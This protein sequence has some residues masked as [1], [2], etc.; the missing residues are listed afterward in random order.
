[1]AKCFAPPMLLRSCPMNLNS[2]YGS[3]K[4]LAEKLE[5]DYNTLHIY[6][7]V[8]SRYELVTRVTSS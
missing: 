8:A 6:Q 5:I 1:M 2:I 4:E 7:W 3:L